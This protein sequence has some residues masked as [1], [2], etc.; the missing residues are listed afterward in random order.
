VRNQLSYLFEKLEASTR[1]E[2]VAR[3]FELALPLE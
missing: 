1:S 3:S 2:A